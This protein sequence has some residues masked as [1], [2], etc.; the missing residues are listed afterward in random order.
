[1]PEDNAN[2]KRKSTSNPKTSYSN[3]TVAQAQ[4]RLGFRFQSLKG[5]PVERMLENAEDSIEAE[6]F[7]KADDTKEEVYREITRY[8]RVE[9][10]PTEA[11]PTFK[12]SSITHLVFATIC[13]I[14]DDFI[15]ISGRK[16]LRLRSE[17]AILSNDGETGGEEE[18]VVMDLISVEEEKYV[19]IVEAKRS[20]LG[21]AIRQCALAMKDMRDYNGEGKVYGFV[22]TG[23]SWQMLEYD[24]KVFR[25]TNNLVVLFE[26]MDEEKERWMKEGAVLVDCINFALSNG[27]IVK[28]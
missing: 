4:S 27:G 6:A 15:R 20:S 5:I 18:F 24:G 8:I 2:K 22:T 28:D 9:G 17:K 3:M 19:L 11:E 21:K 10:Y 12:E 23:E 26:S 1:M 25:K 7:L 13:P 14:I 16:N